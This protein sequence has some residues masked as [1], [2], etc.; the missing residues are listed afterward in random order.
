[1]LGNNGGGGSS[2]GDGCCIDITLV[3]FLFFLSAQYDFPPYSSSSTPIL[4]G[5]TAPP[6]LCASG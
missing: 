6:I 4:G 5:V 2:D 3:V 1:M